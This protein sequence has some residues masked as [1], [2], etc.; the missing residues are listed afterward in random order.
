M[1][2]PTALL[3][4][5]VNKLSGRPSYRRLSDEPEMELP[6]LNGSDGPSLLGDG[7]ETSASMPSSSGELS[8][9]YFGIL[10]IY[11]TIPQFLGTLIATVVFAIL[12]PGKS[13]ELGDGEQ[14]PKQ[15]GPNAIAVCLF[16]G[17]MCSIVA[18]FATRRL[19]NM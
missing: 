15:S 5:E 11:T 18:S 2:A 17:A 8:G 3:G 14:I 13:R 10:N 1:W 12:E 4:I 6:R 9:I 7:P 19:K 16:I